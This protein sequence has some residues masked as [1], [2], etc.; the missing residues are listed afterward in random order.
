[1]NSPESTVVCEDIGRSVEKGK[2]LLDDVEAAVR[3]PVSASAGI[4]EKIIRDNENTEYG[5]KVGLKDVH[6]VDDYRRKVPL[7]VFDDYAELVY[8][9]LTGDGE[10]LC[11]VYGVNQYNKSS[12]TMGNPKKI[13]MSKPSMDLMNGYFID[14]RN[15]LADRMV[16]G[17]SA[18]RTL[19]VMEASSYTFVG[20]NK[21]YVGVSAQCIMDTIDEYKGMFTSPREAT[22]PDPETNSRYLHARC[23]LMDRDVTQLMTSFSTFLLDMFHYIEDNWELL[24][25]DIATGKIDPSIRMTD[26]IRAKLES[27][28]EPMPERAEE[29]RKVF[30]EGFD[31][32]LCRRIWPKMRYVTGI[33]TGTFAA[34]L[35][36]LREHYIG[37]LPVYM[38]G[39]MASEGAFTVPYEFDCPYS[40]PLVNTMFM[41]FLPLDCEDP[42]KTLM[43]HELEVGAEYELI[44]TTM[45]G[46]YRYRTRDAYRVTGMHGGLPML[47]YLYRID[48]CVN[49]NGEKTYEP[50][51]RKAMDISAGKLGFRYT[52]FCVYPNTDTT[53]SCYEFFVEMTKIPRDLTLKVLAETIQDELQ[54][55]NPLLQYKFER[56]LIGPTRANVLQQQ[57]YLLYRDKQ[58]MMGAASTQVKP[59]KIISNEAQLRFF[60]VLTEDIKE[61]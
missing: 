22:V 34:Y 33:S 3:D 48:L 11:C 59:V 27:G 36:N 31:S 58:V 55:I 1:M 13:P 35:A 42:T 51:M 29:L 38:T 14:Y 40:I 16:G 23:G 7:T 49:L 21:R 6:S 15:A 28:F 20:D 25:D 10:G 61:E 17:I 2:R 57:T 32:T 4:F 9:E 41:E 43:A 50:A 54:K 26:E 37:D 52:D 18:G 56:N 60:R 19:C 47:E 45:S 30:S 8:R 53:P 24:C 5:R 46:L 12:G 44:V 39:V